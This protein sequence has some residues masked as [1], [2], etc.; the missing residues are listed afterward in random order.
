MPRNHVIQSINIINGI[1]RSVF[2]TNNIDATP[3]ETSKAVETSEDFEEKIPLT[4]DT[5]QDFII[6]LKSL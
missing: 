1:F 5:A 6:I 3:T 2:Y 4:F